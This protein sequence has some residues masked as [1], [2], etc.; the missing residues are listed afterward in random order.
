MELSHGISINHI[1]AT[2]E[3]MTSRH[4][5]IVPEH[6]FI[7][8]CK[9]EDV[10]AS[11]MAQKLG[12]QPHLIPVLNSEIN[13]LTELFKQFKL[14]PKQA[15]HMLREMLGDGGYQRTD[16][17]AGVHRT[18]ESRAAYELAGQLPSKPRLLSQRCNIS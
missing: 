6:L 18:Q 14:D 4:E 8:L 17:H 5:F 1:L 2:L 15:R 12:L 7:A 11:N 10:P 3:A 16:E 9:L 13:Y